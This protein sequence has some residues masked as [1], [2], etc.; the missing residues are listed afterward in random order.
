MKVWIKN[1][2]AYILD[3]KSLEGPDFLHQYYKIS[4]LAVRGNSVIEGS[5]TWDGPLH[6]EKII[7][8]IKSD[9]R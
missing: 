6:E 1:I 7:D 4:Y 3:V 9:F 2:E 5:K 8:S